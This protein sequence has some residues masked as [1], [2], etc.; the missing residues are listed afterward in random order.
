MSRQQLSP[1]DEAMEEHAAAYALD[2]LEAGDREQF[3]SHLAGCARCATL[4][5]DYRS[6]TTALAL[7]VDEIDASP[8]LR[9]RVM[10]RIA[11]EDLSTAR[12]VQIAPRAGRRTSLW[13]SRH[14]GD[15][16]DIAGV[17]L[18]E[19]DAAERAT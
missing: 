8:G 9:D 7:N 13:G 19:R 12:P 17:W 4:V 2:A 5:R 18:L 11:S 1:H 10:A 14:G 16:V 6:V 3:L 15:A